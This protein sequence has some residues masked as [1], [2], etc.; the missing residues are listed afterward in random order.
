M[1]N[2]RQ[3]INGYSLDHVGSIDDLYDHLGSIDVGSIDLDNVTYHESNLWSM[4]ME[5]SEQFD[6]FT[7]IQP[8]FLDHINPI[9]N[10]L[11]NDS[12]FVTS[13][14]LFGH[15]HEDVESIKHKKYVPLTK[16]YRVKKYNE[17]PIQRDH[18][19]SLCLKTLLDKAIICDQLGNFVSCYIKEIDADKAVFPSR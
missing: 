19:C 4:Y 18:I 7:N 10:E 13:N 6:S 8:S 16:Y 11:H 14:S 1:E 15:P 17:Y 12:M 2:D 3:S 9:F 5:N